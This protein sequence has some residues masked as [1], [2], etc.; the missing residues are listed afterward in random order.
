MSERSTSGIYV[1]LV[2]LKIYIWKFRL[3]FIVKIYNE[4]KPL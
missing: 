1:F 2:L 3:G 4:T